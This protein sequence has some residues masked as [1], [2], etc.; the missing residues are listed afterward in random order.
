MVVEITLV[1]F[2]EGFDYIAGFGCSAFDAPQREPSNVFVALADCGH[3]EVF[4]FQGR[5]V[6]V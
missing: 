3:C 5:Y 6:S 2:D 1:A 4:H